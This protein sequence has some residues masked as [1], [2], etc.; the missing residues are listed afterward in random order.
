MVSHERI[1]LWIYQQK[2][3]GVDYCGYLRKGH[4][5]RRK[6]KNKQTSRQIIK[7]KT[8]IEDR[9]EVVKKQKRVGD[10]EVDLVQCRKGYLLTATDRKTLF[11]WVGKVADKS[12]RTVQEKLIKLL[13]PYKT[14]LKTVTSDNGLEFASHHKISKELQVDWYFA[15]PYC[16]HER[17]CNE[18]QNGLLR[19]Y[20]PRSTDLSK[21]SKTTVKNW[22]KT[23]NARP[24][25]KLNFE[26]P[27]SQFPAD[28]ST[29]A[30]AP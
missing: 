28:C 27:K 16:A 2:R 20:A 22:Q 26:P 15:H 13:K 21:I 23:L 10:I 24:R 8:S 17:G 29:V 5:S 19:Q 9:P 18:N 30:F 4:R 14:H 1:Y 11:N 7:D 6:R 12:A 3:K 25:K